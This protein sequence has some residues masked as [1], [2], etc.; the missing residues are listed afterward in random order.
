MD[1]IFFV[2]YEYGDF[3]CIQGWIVTTTFATIVH[4]NMFTC[5]SLKMWHVGI[6]WIFWNILPN[7]YI[8]ST[9]RLKQLDCATWQLKIAL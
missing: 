8:F 1:E 4:T 9:I 6:I 3:I 5:G 7:I 2:K